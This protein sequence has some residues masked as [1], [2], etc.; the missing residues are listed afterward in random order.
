MYEFPIFTI[1]EYA[2]TDVSYIAT[3]LN[4]FQLHSSLSVPLQQVRAYRCD[5]I[6]GHVMPSWVS[7]NITR[8][9]MSSH[10]S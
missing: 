7:G 6:T 2:T 3:K 4:S 1:G 5:D 10:G 8:P 9:M